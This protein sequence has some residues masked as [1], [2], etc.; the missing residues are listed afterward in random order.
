MMTS[1]YCLNPREKLKKKKKVKKKSSF[2]LVHT[3]QKYYSPFKYTYIYLLHT[4]RKS[5]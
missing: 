2:I 5:T 3:N 1:K 4:L